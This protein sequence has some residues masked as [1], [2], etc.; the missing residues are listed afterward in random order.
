MPNGDHLR[1]HIPQIFSVYLICQEGLQARHPQEF[2]EARQNSNPV[3]KA[4]KAETQIAFQ[5]FV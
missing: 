3:G 5:V 1:T 2:N 4:R